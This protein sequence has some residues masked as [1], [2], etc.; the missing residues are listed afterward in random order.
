MKTIKSIKPMETIY[1]GHRFRSRLEARWAFFFNAV[2]IKYVYEMDRYPLPGAS[3][4]TY[5]PDF[6]L[7]YSKET[8]TWSKYRGYGHWFEVKGVD[9]TEEEIESLL[10]LSILTGH[11]GILVVGL[12]GEHTQLVTSRSGTYDW[13]NDDILRD[14]GTII[15]KSAERNLE[16]LCLRFDIVDADII[17][18][19][20]LAKMER[21]ENY[22]PKYHRGKKS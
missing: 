4:P 14:D 11:N 6:W 8:S 1:D 5:L 7:P 19:C 2:G 18:S 17:G 21:F 3:V 20:R 13:W 9:P 12:P 15:V 16:V 22:Y 10:D